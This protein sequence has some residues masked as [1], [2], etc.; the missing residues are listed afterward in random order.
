MFNALDCNKIKR[1]GTINKKR[2]EN[3]QGTLI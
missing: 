3:R 1:N 2:T